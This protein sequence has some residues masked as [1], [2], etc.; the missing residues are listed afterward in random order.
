LSLRLLFALE[1]QPFR[2]PPLRLF[3]GERVG[4]H[5]T[6]W[7][8]RFISREGGFGSARKGETIA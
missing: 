8:R 3:S 2:A 6:R 1:W 5:E 7:D 4:G